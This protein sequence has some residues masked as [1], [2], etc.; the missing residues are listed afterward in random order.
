MTNSY[1]L[2]RYPL[3]PALLRLT[4]L[5]SL[6]WAYIPEAES[7]ESDAVD[8]DEFEKE[9]E[10]EPNSII[11]ANVSSLRS[12]T[13]AGDSIWQLPVRTFSSLTE[14][15]IEESGSLGGLDIVF[16]HATQ[17][18]AMR[19]SGILSSE[20]SA[21]LQRNTS[22][23]PL[24]HS[25]SLRSGVLE[26]SVEEGQAIARF[27]QGRPCLQ[28]LDLR[29]YLLHWTAFTRVLPPVTD[30]RAL[31]VLGLGCGEESI[32][33]NVSETLKEYLSDNLEAVSLDM[34]AADNDQISSGLLAD[35]VRFFRL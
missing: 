16:H 23:L 25:L 19:L 22:A 10:I 11:V 20:L 4:K 31:K 6:T 8:V 7:Y 34:P 9:I 5:T 24:L 17:L 28:R 35:L 18:Q 33:S 13:C 1:E 29:F 3:P 26:C 30:L 2:S 14:L 15:N 21:S 27:I 32:S 12:L